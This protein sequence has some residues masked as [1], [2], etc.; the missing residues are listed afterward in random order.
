MVALG[1]SELS[2]A[3][4]GI[5]YA[6]G[7]AGCHGMLCGALVVD[8]ALSPDA[9]WPE[10]VEDSRATDALGWETKQLLIRTCEMIRQQFADPQCGFTLLLPDDDTPLKERIQAVAQWC[11]GFLFGLALLG[12]RFDNALS[13]IGRE[14]LQ[15]FTEMTRI[16]IDRVSD[17]NDEFAY[18]EIVEHLRVSV[19]ILV[20]DL[21]APEVSAGKQ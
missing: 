10:I 20:D 5:G 1:Y 21:H 13:S 18:A 15:D 8:P 17:E 3:V 7:A 14:I 16:Y 6:Y 12:L 4:D 2:S 19:L 9:W 11:D